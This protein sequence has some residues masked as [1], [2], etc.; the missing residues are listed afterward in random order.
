MVCDT[1]NL[2]IDRIDDVVRD[3]LAYLLSN[4]YGDA[5]EHDRGHTMVGNE[6]P[7]SVV[8]ADPRGCL[9]QQQACAI[10]RTWRCLHD[11]PGTATSGDDSDS[12]GLNR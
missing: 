9:K 3:A 8:L 11:E 10:I 5:T 6:T 7:P 1:T 12:D 2:W 4:E